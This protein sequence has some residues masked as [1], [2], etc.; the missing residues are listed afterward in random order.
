[1]LSSFWCKRGFI[2]LGIYHFTDYAPRVIMALPFPL[3]VKVGT[4]K[5]WGWVIVVKRVSRPEPSP[6]WIEKMKKIFANEKKNYKMWERKRGYSA[7][8]RNIFFWFCVCANHIEMKY[9]H[10]VTDSVWLKDY[11]SW[12]LGEER[13]DNN[14]KFGTF[15]AAAEMKK[16]LMKVLVEAP[17]LGRPPSLHL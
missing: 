16:R 8:R 13:R 7:P 17:R 9:F 10:L 1:M 6:E 5:K 12:S 4:E 2:F 15:P 11:F 14:F 3:K